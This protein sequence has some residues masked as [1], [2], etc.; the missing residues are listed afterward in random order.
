MMFTILVEVPMIKARVWK[1]YNPYIERKL[2][3]WFSFIVATL[4][5]NITKILLYDYC[6]VIAP[7]RAC[8]YLNLIEIYNLASFNCYSYSNIRHN[9]YFNLESIS[10][11]SIYPYIK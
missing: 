10:I 4:R 8:L 5:V 6:W 1:D 3:P 9:I 7:Y 2:L 11:F